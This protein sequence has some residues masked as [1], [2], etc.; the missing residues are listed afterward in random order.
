MGAA[1]DN[2]KKG[3]LTLIVSALVAISTVFLTNALNNRDYDEKQFKEEV[4][5]K[6]S[7]E[8]VDKADGHLQKQIDENKQSDKEIRQQFLIEVQG[9]RAD[10][11]E[12]YLQK[13]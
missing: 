1:Y 10:I 3:W 11:K 5:K 8:Y 9:L 13:R 6:A 12:L 2:L 7:Y 4:S